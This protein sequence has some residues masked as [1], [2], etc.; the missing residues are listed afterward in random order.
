[1]CIGIAPS[2]TVLNLSL[3]DEALYA[4]NCHYFIRKRYPLEKLLI[5]GKLQIDAINSNFENEIWN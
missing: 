1:M 3:V 5:R 2:T 4:K